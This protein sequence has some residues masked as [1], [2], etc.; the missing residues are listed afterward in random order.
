MS[1]E[2]IKRRNPGHRWGKGESGNPEGRPKT[3]RRKLV[4]R[5]IADLLASWETAG[6]DV[7]ER[8]RAEF[9]DIYALAVGSLVQKGDR[10]RGK[11]LIDEHA[12]FAARFAEAQADLN[13]QIRTGNCG[14]ESSPH[15]DGTNRL[16]EYRPYLKQAAFHT[17]GALHDER[18]LMA[19]NQ[20]GKTLA[21]AMEW[22]M[23]LT[24]RYPDW[25]KGRVFDHP[26]RMWAAGVTAES[27]RDNP[28]RVLI[29]SPQ[30]KE[31]WGTG[32][33]PKD[34]LEQ[35]TPSPFPDAL[36]SVV[37]RW[38][39]GGDVQHR[40]SVLA[41]KSYEKGREKW[42]GETLDGVWFDE[43]PPIA[44]YSEGRTRTVARRGIVIVTL[45]PL[46]GMTELVRLF[47]SEVDVEKMRKG[48]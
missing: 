1:I 14:A 36:D 29:G 9:P 16:A 35:W 43:E 26:V 25:W 42:Q 41:F 19:G 8:L 34:A 40:E 23:H 5:F 33:I 18:L 17:A 39:G 27:T 46:L 7:I 12:H 4:D 44:I 15:E 11:R 38:G 22:A 37:V 48:P 3:S 32:T 6:K 21:G 28:Q 45:T 2:P 30:Q 20:L 24:G 31:K 13:A 10:F 47:L